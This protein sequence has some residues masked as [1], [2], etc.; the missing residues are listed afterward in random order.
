MNRRQ[1]NNN[2]SRN[3]LTQA[4]DFPNITYLALFRKL[5][6]LFEVNY[7]KVTLVFCK[8]SAKVRADKT[9]ATNYRNFPNHWMSLKVIFFAA[10]MKLAS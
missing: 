2:I 10:T 9:C 5:S 6:T 8:Q 4:F 7:L 1:M 3:E